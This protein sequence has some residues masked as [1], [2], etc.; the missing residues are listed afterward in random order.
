[1]KKDNLINFLLQIVCV[2]KCVEEKIEEQRK[3][4]QL[5]MEGKRL[6]VNIYFAQ[7][8]KNEM[9]NIIGCLIIASK[10]TMMR[11]ISLFLLWPLSELNICLK[12]E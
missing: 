1:M 10:A 5:E 3:Q 2:E 9:R 7:Q 6:Q 12:Y 4:K 11:R 8:H